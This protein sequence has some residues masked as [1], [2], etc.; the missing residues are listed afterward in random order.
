MRAPPG[1]VKKRSP[2]HFQ[3]TASYALSRF[4]TTVADGLGLGGGALGNR[5]VKGNFGTGGADR[6][7]GLVLNGVA[8]LPAGFGASLI[9]PW[10]SGLP[11]SILVGSADLLGNGINGSLLPGT[12]RGSLGRDLDS[13]QK[14]NSLIVAYNQSTAGKPL[15]RGGRAP[16]LLEVPDSVRFGDSFIS[17]DLQLAKDVKIPEKVS[18]ELTAQ[19]CNLFI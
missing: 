14:L 1:G 13:V 2:R 10:Y 6:T 4:Q 17:Q 3:Y 15:P 18:I 8:N 12:H 5:N 7:Q 16:F 19:M 9:S 11:A